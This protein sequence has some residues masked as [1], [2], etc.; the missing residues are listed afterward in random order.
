MKINN[1]LALLSLLS[2]SNLLFGQ[3]AEEPAPV[4]RKIRPLGGNV[5]VLKALQIPPVTSEYTRPEKPL[6]P[7][8][9]SELNRPATVL[10]VSTYNFT[11]TYQV[12]GNLM[13]I[14]LKFEADQQANAG[15]IPNTGEA[16]LNYIL[17]KIAQNP[18]SYITPTS[19]LATIQFNPGATGSG[20]FITPEGHIV[21]NAHV[22]EVNKATFQSMAA[23]QIL[24]AIIDKEVNALINEYQAEPDEKIFKACA[25]SIY[26]YYGRYLKLTNEQVVYSV[27]TGKTIEDPS[28]QL[29]ATLISKGGAIPNKDVAIL[30]VQ[31]NNFPT[32]AFG[33]DR[34]LKPGHKLYVMGYPGAIE[35]NEILKADK[36]KEPSFTEGMMNA[37]QETTQGWTAIQLDAA[38]YRGN[39]GG[40]VFNEYGEV[41]GLLTFGSFNSERT[42]LVQ[43]FNFIVPAH[44]VGEFTRAAQIQPRAGVA[45]NAYRESIF[46]KEE[47]PDK[48]SELLA[49]VRE[50]NADWPYITQQTAAFSVGK[51]VTWYG[52]FWENFKNRWYTYTGLI[53]AVLYALYWVFSKIFK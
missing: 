29:P 14:F 26:Q 1:T 37:R 28:Y 20:A 44:I 50:Y 4:I 22:V 30:K 17:S 10:V 36:M 23:E 35:K 51:P 48:A 33:E 7:S 8:E 21:T 19:T 42:D 43:G 9:I 16:K 49:K 18:G 2:L 53:L 6:T 45:M 3:V 13:M 31:G 25:L 47:D 24:S 34:L 11:V 40:P 12:P 15:R 41:V 46:L 27:K 32:I 38:T 39:S 52:L 5:G